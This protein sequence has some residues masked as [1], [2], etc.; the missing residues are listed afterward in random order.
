LIKPFANL[1][2][3]RRKKTQI[4][5]IKDKVGDIIT[6]IEWNLEDHEGILWKPILKWKKIEEI[7]KF[8]DALT[9]QNL[10]KRI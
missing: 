9:Y 4:N 3:R 10:I 8:P 6:N 1:T 2:K 7:D 5:K